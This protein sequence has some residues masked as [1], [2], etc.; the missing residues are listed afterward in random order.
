MCLSTSSA[1]PATSVC[2]V[3]PRRT[4]LRRRVL[5]QVGDESAVAMWVDRHTSANYTLLPRPS[6]TGRTTDS[7]HLFL[8]ECFHRSLSDSQ[9]RP[10]PAASAVRSVV[11]GR[12]RLWSA[13]IATQSC[14]TRAVNFA[15]S[16]SPHT[17]SAIDRQ[18]VCP[19]SDITIDLISGCDGYATPRAHAILSRRAHK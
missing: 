19:S 13:S 4:G 3:I 7:E 16:V 15:L 10:I 17:C 11:T 9:A 14:S 1:D 5:E 2:P 6:S 12:I 18:S 8:V